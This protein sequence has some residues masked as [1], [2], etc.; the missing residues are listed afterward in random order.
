[1]KMEKVICSMVATLVFGLASLPA[2]AGETENAAERPVVVYR[3]QL[4]NGANGEKLAFGSKTNVVMTF[5]AYNSD[6]ASAREIWCS[7]GVDKDGHK[8][9]VSVPVDPD[10]SFACTLGD[11]ALIA[12]IVTGKVTLVKEGSAMNYAVRLIP[13]GASQELVDVEKK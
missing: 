7:D 4:I 11:D 13:F 3:G 5:R 6:D 1:M 9:R 8:T 10:G 2:N 12:N